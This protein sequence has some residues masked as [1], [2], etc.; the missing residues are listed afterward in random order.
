MVNPTQT[1]SIRPAACDDARAIGE[2]HLSSWQT[3]Y[4]GLGIDEFLDSET[5]EG[6]AARWAS[7]LCDPASQTFVYVAE[8]DG[9][10]VGFAAGGPERTGDPEYKG[11]LYAIYL[12]KAHQGKGIGRMLVR[13]VAERL[14][15]SGLTTM[16][17]WVLAVNPACFFYE[18]CGGKAV[19]QRPSE[20]GG[21]TFDEIG[22]GWLDTRT[23]LTKEA[24]G[25]SQH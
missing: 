24:Q 12:L 20:I 23:V 1:A 13:V 25:D 11:E 16:L 18:A 17:I 2:V 5:V 6:R 4:R 9:Q 8:V 21:K 3:T 7:M 10:L 15:R 14:T 22:Y 19:R